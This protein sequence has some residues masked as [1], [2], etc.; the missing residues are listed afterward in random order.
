MF[1]LLFFSL[2]F[3]QII[4]MLIVYLCWLYVYADSILFMLTVYMHIL[5]AFKYILNVYFLENHL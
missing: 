3:L 5:K 1:L 4:S 2:I